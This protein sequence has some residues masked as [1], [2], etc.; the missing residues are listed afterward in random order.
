MTTYTTI[1]NSDIDPDSPVTTSLVTLLRDNPLAIGEGASGA[2][3]IARA[4]VA[5]GVG[6]RWFYDYGDESDGAKTVSADETIAPGLYQYST[7]L[8]NVTKTV[9]LSLKGPL[10][11][12]AT[13]SIIIN[14]TI[15]VDGMGGAGGDTPGTTN[16][17]AGQSGICGGSGGG[18]NGASGGDGGNT[19][20]TAGGAA[21]AG[22]GAAQST[23][24]KNLLLAVSPFFNVREEMLIAAGREYRTPVTRGDAAVGGGGGGA[25]T[26]ASGDDGGAGGGLIILVSPVVTIGAAGVLT[27]DGTS[28]HANGGAGGGGAIIIA[29]PSGAYTN[30]GSVAASGAT[31]ASAGNGG[32]GW[33]QALTL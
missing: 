26:G 5:A 23:I 21:S 10:I 17:V 31:S 25:S 6:H 16:D 4:A 19:F 29:T 20:M 27:A 2:P 12:V 9:D 7:Y 3:R 13:T 8:L 28:I 32:A 15:D 11:I 30:N 24:T 14:G 18:G 22:N 1:P 33:V